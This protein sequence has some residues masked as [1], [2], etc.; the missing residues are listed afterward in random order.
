MEIVLSSEEIVLPQRQSVTVTQCFQE[1]R[2]RGALLQSNQM[3]PIIRA[4]PD[5]LCLQ[6]VGGA[7]EAHRPALRAHQ[8]GL[9]GG[10]G[11]LPFDAAQ[12]RAVADSSCTKN[13][14]F[15]VSQIVRRE[16]AAQIFFVSVVDQFYQSLII[17]R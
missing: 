12:K 14:V 1:S 15:A 11:T 17:P 4:K 8:N 3:F 16:N 7:D 5:G 9:R 6:I 10:R 2:P 13:D